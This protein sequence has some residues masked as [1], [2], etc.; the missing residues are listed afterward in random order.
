MGKIRDMLIKKHVTQKEGNVK[1]Q[2]NSII[3]RLGDR[4]FGD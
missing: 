3:A 1:K 4:H 2:I